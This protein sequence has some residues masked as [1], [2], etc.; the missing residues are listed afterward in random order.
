MDDGKEY[1][2]MASCI[3]A[4]FMSNKSF[5]NFASKDLKTNHDNE[6]NYYNDAIDWHK[7]YEEWASNRYS[8]KNEL[9]EDE[10]VSV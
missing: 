9:I 3:L 7:R 8:V 6:R 1:L 2:N 10:N 5:C 4:W